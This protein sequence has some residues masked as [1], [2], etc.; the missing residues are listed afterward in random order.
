[1]KKKDLL[2]SIEE[3]FEIESGLLV[4]ESMLEDIDAWD[5]LGVLNLISLVDEKVGVVLSPNDLEKCQ[6]LADVLAL[7]ADKLED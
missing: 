2:S 1:M 4:E 3:I 5:S 6:T 7:F